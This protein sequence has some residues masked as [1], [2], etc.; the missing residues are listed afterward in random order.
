MKVKSNH[1]GC[2]YYV[3]VYYKD[4]FLDELEYGT[5]DKEHALR[6]AQTKF[7]KWAFIVDLIRSN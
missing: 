1:M 2:H 4:T 7:S 5:P 3:D 6:V